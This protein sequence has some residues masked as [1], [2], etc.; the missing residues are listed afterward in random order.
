MDIAAVTK[1]CKEKGVMSVV[2]NTFL[3]PYFQNPLN[4]GADIVVH[5]GTKYLCGHAD[6]VMG[7]IITSNKE[8]YDK[9][10]FLAYT[11]GPIPGPFDCYLALRSL[12]TLPVRMEAIN[13]NA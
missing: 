4:L 6:V 3:S 11:M 13:R 10:F 1:I 2:D 5:S 12:K 9:L 8:I 7:F